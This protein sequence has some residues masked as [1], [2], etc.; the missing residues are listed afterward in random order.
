MYSVGNVDFKLYVIGNSKISE[1][2]DYNSD[3]LAFEKTVQ[4]IHY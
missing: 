2:F 1:I 4:Q 3:V